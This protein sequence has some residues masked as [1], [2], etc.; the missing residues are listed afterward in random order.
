M[1]AMIGYASI[2]VPSAISGQD[3]A[4]AQ[5]RMSFDRALCAGR[6][7]SRALVDEFAS[8][9]VPLGGLHYPYG[10]GESRASRWHEVGHNAGA[11]AVSANF[12]SFPNQ[13]IA[14]IVLANINAPAA[15]EVMNAA[16]IRSLPTAW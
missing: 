14:I 6:R 15:D 2:H 16:G 8:G 13:G 3:I 4:T 7:V 9:E 11:P 5:D 1:G 10:F 12:K